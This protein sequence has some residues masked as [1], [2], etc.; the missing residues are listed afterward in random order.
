MCLK[1]NIHPCLL[2]SGKLAGDRPAARDVGA[3]TVVL[4]PEVKQAHVPL[5]DGLVVG[6]TC[7]QR[8]IF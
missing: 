5:L 6:C 4:G 2:V 1:E 7:R 8:Y 3:E